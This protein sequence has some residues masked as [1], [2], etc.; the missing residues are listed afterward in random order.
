MARRA[1]TWEAMKAAILEEGG[2]FH[3]FGGE[4]LLVRDDDLEELFRW[5]FEQFG[6]NQIQ[7]NGVLLN[8]RHIEIFQRYNV[9]AGIS[10][11]GP[12]ELNDARW[13]GS[14]ERTR[15][16]TAKSL[17]AID[18]LCDAGIVPAVL[19]Q[20]TRCNASRER[21]PLML[22]W[23]HAL[24]RKG[25]AAVR[26][27]ILEIESPTVREHL[28]LTID[29]NIHA[30]SAFIDLES[31]LAYVRFDISGDMRNLLLGRDREAACVWRC[32]R[33]LHN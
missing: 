25:I 23:I 16:S 5:G 3:L 28:S 20:L 29:E 1:T 19:T 12:T 8:D 10:I 9:T 18:R 33:S 15:E 13:A 21:L 7:T 2:P 11:D 32:L 24:D 17:H 27:H 6:E 14:L 4:P 31:Q 26:L 22:D 30:L